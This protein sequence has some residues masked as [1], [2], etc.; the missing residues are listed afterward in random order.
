ML[1]SLLLWTGVTSVLLH[2]SRIKANVEGSSHIV[3]LLIFYSCWAFSATEN[4]E[5]QWI[6]AKKATNET[7]NLSP[8]QI[9][10]CD[11]NDAGC[12]GGVPSIVRFYK[13]NNN[14]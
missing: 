5:S 9:V 2:L 10:D 14:I 6:L 3:I 11:M 7:V 12:D 4:I 8:Q 1:S 13:L